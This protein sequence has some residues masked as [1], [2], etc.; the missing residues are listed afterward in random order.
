MLESFGTLLHG[1]P[2]DK[3]EINRVRDVILFEKPDLKKK[4][5]RFF[6]LLVLAAGISTYGLL[7]NSVATIIGAMIVAPL[8]L[9]IMGLAFSISIGDGYAI[10]NSLLILF[11]GI[12]NI[13]AMPLITATPSA[14]EPPKP[15]E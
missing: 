2:V 11:R 6:S 3:D 13:L 9:P 8:M 15:P 5:V 4:L 10:K 12:S 1:D 7:S 14:V